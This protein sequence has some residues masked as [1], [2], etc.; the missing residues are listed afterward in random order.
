MPFFRPIWCWE[1]VR[2]SG[3]CLNIAYLATNPGDNE[4]IWFMFALDCSPHRAYCWKLT[5]WF[6]S[7]ILN[8]IIKNPS[9]TCGYTPLHLGNKNSTTYP[10]H[11]H[12]A[13]PL[14]LLP[15]FF[16]IPSGQFFLLIGMFNPMTNLLWR[17]TVGFILG[18]CQTSCAID[19]AVNYSQR[20]TFI[21]IVCRSWHGNRLDKQLTN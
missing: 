13:A 8:V 19:K 5:T 14:I 16:C 12:N 10:W 3:T 1:R 2:G 9:R 7:Y 20:S 6:V 4:T 21:L 17:S 15:F 11:W 18:G